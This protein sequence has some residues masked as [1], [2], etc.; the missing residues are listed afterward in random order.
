MI[1][2][3]IT[4]RLLLGKVETNHTKCTVI[5]LRTAAR[6]AVGLKTMETFLRKL[7][8]KLTMTTVQIAI[9]GTHGT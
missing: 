3:A 9:T 4:M 1:V 2:A 5:P 7:T 8:R 6:E